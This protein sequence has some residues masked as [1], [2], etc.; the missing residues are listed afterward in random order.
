MDCFFIQ[1]QQSGKTLLQLIYNIKRNI[2]VPLQGNSKHFVELDYTGHYFSDGIR[3]L[4]YK[5]PAFLDKYPDGA[6][7]IESNFQ[8]VTHHVPH[9]LKQTIFYLNTDSLILRNSSGFTPAGV[10]NSLRYIDKD[11][12]T[13]QIVDSVRIINGL[14]CRFATLSSNNGNI[15][16]SIWFFSDIPMFAG[17]NG[18]FNTPGLIVEAQS[19]S[20]NETFTL[21]SFEMPDNL[22]EKTFWPEEFNYTFKKM[23]DLKANATTTPQNEKNKQRYE[24]MNQ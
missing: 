19:Y 6:I 22:P 1:H 5:T 10:N 17:I 13:W 21:V 18:L 7:L 2:S 9:A 12:R 8:T 4:Y 20:T 24:I 3:H 11:Y 14:P 23:R 16:C 15:I